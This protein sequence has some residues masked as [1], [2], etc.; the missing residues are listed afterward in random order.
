[1]SQIKTIDISD[2]KAQRPYDLLALY[3]RA[4]GLVAIDSFPL[5]LAKAV[6]ALTTVALI[7]D[8]PSDWHRSAPRRH[9]SLRVLYSEAMNR[10]PAIVDTLLHPPKSPR[11]FVVT[12][13]PHAQASPDSLRRRHLAE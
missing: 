4:Q 9:H 2:L 10:F 3:E 11:L 12:N 8:G 13:A 5:H 7:V 6:P 1:A